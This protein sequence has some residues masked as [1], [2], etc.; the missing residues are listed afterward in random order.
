MTIGI[1]AGRGG[2]EGLKFSQNL[3]NLEFFCLFFLKREIFYFKLKS[4]W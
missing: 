4:G 3:G 2:G 1:C